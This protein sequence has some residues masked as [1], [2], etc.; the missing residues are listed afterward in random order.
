MCPYH[1]L[2]KVIDHY[3]KSGAYDERRP[4]F[5]TSVGKMTKKKMVV[6]SMRCVAR[7]AHQGTDKNNAD[8]VM[9][10]SPRIVGAQHYA[11][12]G[13]EM[14]IIEILGRWG[15]SSIRR[16][17]ADA[18]LAKVPSIYKELYAKRDLAAT[19]AEAIKDALDDSAKEQMLKKR[20]TA[21]DHIDPADFT[22]FKQKF[23][24]MKSQMSILRTLVSD[25]IEALKYAIKNTGIVEGTRILEA[26]RLKLHIVRV[27]LPLQPAQ[28]RTFCGWSFGC[29]NF[30]AYVE[31][32]RSRCPR[33]LALS[34]RSGPPPPAEDLDSGLSEDSTS[35]SDGL[36]GTSPNEGGGSADGQ[37]TATSSNNLLLLSACRLA[38]SFS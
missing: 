36:F 12:L 1:E 17:V 30:K 9:A 25:D 7:T 22:A 10:H 23:K 32:E 11:G 28:W 4:L 38:I 5:G 6:R 8:E 13:F 14:A 15:G 2:D 34:S 20:R 27:G 21:G 31:E 37:F 16:Y 24:N 26:A 18:P 35:T 29:T 33:C 19:R 3:E